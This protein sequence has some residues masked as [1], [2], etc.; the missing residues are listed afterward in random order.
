[1]HVSLNEFTL[2]C[3]RAL[4][5]LGFPA[6]DFEDAADMVVWLEQHGLG[7]AQLLGEIL[8]RLQDNHWPSLQRHHDDG[9]CVVLEMDNGS[10]LN[11]GSLAADLAC[12]RAMETGLGIVRLQGCLDRSFIL[13]YLA[14]CARRG[15]HIAALWCTGQPRRAVQNVG[16]ALAFDRLP[17]LHRFRAD[18]GGK[19]EADTATL[20]LF[21][22]RDFAM[23]PATPPD[24][25]S[26]ELLECV[27]SQQFDA[28]A[29][30]A[31]DQGIDVD[32]ALWR[33]LHELARRKLV[34]DSATS[35]ARGA[36]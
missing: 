16:V 32:E 8:P 3:R 6:G 7:G 30:R 1:M 10:L 28:R 5:S 24:H 23:L 31:W 19:Q 33:A 2:V 18:G 11:G 27:T 22:S 34:A 4:D 9:G 20:T 35:R 29:R 12:I 15:H 14:R 25:P 36:G 21:A 26:I 13:V 17:V